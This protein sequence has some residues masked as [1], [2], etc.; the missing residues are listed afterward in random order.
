MTQTKGM[1]REPEIG[2]LSPELGHPGLRSIAAPNI[3]RLARPPRPRSRLWRFLNLFGDANVRLYRLS[4]GRIGGRMGRA[5]VLLLHHVGRKSGTPRVTPVLF[6]ADGAQLVIVGSKG[7]AAKSPAWVGNLRAHPVTIVETGRRRFQVRAREATEAE[8][9]MYWPRLVA[10]Y[11]SFDLYQ[12]RT[13][14]ILP[15]LILELLDAA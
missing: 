7:G 6:L 1:S 8:R 4:G 10:M 15:V 9:E 5:P 13:D 14:R 3:G 2:R 11:P 12:K